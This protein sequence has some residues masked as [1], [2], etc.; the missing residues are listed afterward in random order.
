MAGFRSMERAQP[1]AL[2]G[3]RHHPHAVAALPP[4]TLFEADA[5]P[6]EPV[7]LLGVSKVFSAAGS[8][9]F[10]AL[11]DVDLALPPGTTVLVKG[12]SGSGKTTLLGLIACLV[13]PTAGR[14]R[15]GE[16]EVTRLPEEQ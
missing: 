4:R 9:G 16:R 1:A 12:P 13:R 10:A 7:E 5:R 14:I 2:R 8:P 6:A 11:A 15:V 3:A